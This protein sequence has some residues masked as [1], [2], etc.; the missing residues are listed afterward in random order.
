[1]A[2][3]RQD[4][5]IS[6]VVAFLSWTVL[7]RFLPA[8][9][10]IP[11]AF[12]AGVLTAVAGLL[13]LILSTVNHEVATERHAPAHTSSLVF[14]LPAAFKVEVAQLRQRLNY[15]QS[16]TYLPSSPVTLRLN[17]LVES[18]IRDFVT[19]WYSKISTD[20]AFSNEVDNTLREAVRKL[21]A[22]VVYLDWADIAVV[23]IL[24]TINGHLKSF[25][26]ADYAVRGKNLDLAESGE[27]DAA[28]AAKYKDGRLHP[29]TSAVALDTTALQQYHLRRVV[30]RLLPELLPDNMTSSNAVLVIARELVACAVLS[31]VMQ[32]LADPDTINQLIEAYVCLEVYAF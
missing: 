14:A 2:L 27:L 9:R 1:M 7:S 31:P 10:W 28:I 23:R 30:G 8:L 21:I 18:V 32:L 24:P 12:I 26:D 20:N 19:S 25:V 6:C 13:Y 11:Y 22:K 29:A 3:R 16:S 15:Q 17:K 5:I 4:V